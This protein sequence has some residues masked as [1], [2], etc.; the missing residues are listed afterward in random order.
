MAWVDV[1]R[2]DVLCASVDLLRV[3]FDATDVLLKQM[4]EVHD[5]LALELDLAILRRK[6]VR[7]LTLLRSARLHSLEFY[8]RRFDS[9]RDRSL[10]SFH[11][12]D[13]VVVVDRK[14]LV[15]DLDLAQ[16]STRWLAA[17]EDTSRTVSGGVR[18]TRRHDGLVTGESDGE[19]GDD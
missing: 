16:V 8:L 3:P 1:L 6:R 12:L 9:V 4:L 10:R 11:L 15:A 13:V 5:L 14:V 17:R 18:R 2:R 7:S 19:E